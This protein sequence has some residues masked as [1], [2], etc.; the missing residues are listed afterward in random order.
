MIFA[1]GL[2]VTRKERE[3]PH[4]RWLLLF[5]ALACVP[6]SLLHGQ[7]AVSGALTGEVTDPSGALIPERAY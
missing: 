5:A 2:R 3:A 1:R 6:L 4:S 7:N